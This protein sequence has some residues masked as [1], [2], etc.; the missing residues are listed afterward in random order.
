MFFSK[1]E[2]LPSDMASYEFGFMKP[3]KA[4]PPNS[5]VSAQDHRREDDGERYQEEE[6]CSRLGTRELPEL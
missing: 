1:K 2:R 6:N 5:R 4:P 3:K